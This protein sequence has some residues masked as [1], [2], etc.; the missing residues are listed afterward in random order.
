M[1]HATSTL[2]HWPVPRI[3]HTPPQQVIRRTRANAVDPV[4]ITKISTGE[5]PVCSMNKPSRPL[6]YS[7][8]LAW[9]K[10]SRDKISHPRLSKAQP[11]ARSATRLIVQDEKPYRENLRRKRLLHNAKLKQPAAL[12]DIDYQHPE[13]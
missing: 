12:E 13:V 11:R 10:A 6:T 9:P 4:R 8:S 3:G 5:N 2:N 7:S 1:H